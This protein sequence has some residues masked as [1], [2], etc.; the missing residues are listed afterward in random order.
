MGSLEDKRF[1]IAWLSVILM[2]GIALLLGYAGLGLYAAGIFFLGLG[3]I[4][5]ALAFGMGKREPLQ[6]G[7]GAVLAILGAVV[8]L[9]NTGTDLLLVAGGVLA[10]T[11]LAAM[12]YLIAKK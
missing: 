8:L 5:L 9:V 12:V 3:L 7:F 6:T 10:G 11:A 2:L 1:R 4:I